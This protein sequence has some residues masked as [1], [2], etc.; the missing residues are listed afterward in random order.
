MN[1]NGRDDANDLPETGPSGRPAAGREGTG[2]RALARL[3]TAVGVWGPAVCWMAFIAWLSSQ[4]EPEGVSPMPFE[5]GDT[6][7]H[8]GLYAVLGALLWRATRRTGQ[9]LLSRRPGQWA[10]AIG[11]SYGVVDELHQMFV[12]TRTADVRDVA[13]DGLGTAAGIVLALALSAWR[14]RG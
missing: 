12:P 6:V 2:S 1:G 13:I 4:P 14:R 3:M 8:L 11:W 10:L 5:V 9:H 7:A